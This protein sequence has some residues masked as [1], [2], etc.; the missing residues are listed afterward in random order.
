MPVN[1]STCPT[2]V[3]IELYTT[4][5]CHLCEDA[6]ALLTRAQ[7]AGNGFEICEVE[8]ADSECLMKR[9]GVR[10]P[11]IRDDEA[12]ELGWPFDYDELQSFIHHSK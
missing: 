1:F 8:I 3:K 11:V 2:A 9:Y 10:I 12:N 4:L 6:L 7:Q 5:G